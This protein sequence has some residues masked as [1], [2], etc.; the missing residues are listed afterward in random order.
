[1]CQ[2]TM[3]MKLGSLFQIPSTKPVWNAPLRINHDDVIRRA[4]KPRYRGNHASQIKSYQ[5][6]LLVSHGRSFRIRHENLPAA[7]PSGEITMTSYSP[8]NETSLSR[9][10]CI[11]DKKLIWNNQ[12]LLESFSTILGREGPGFILV[13]LESTYSQ[14]VEIF[15]WLRL[16]IN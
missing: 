11:P 3:I 9:K 13:L 14:S 12:D 1:M 15:Q 2:W 16:F 7:P 10:P 5:G 6:T 4:I 8:C